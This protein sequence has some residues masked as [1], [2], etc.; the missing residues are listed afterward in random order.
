MTGTPL[1][2]A[3]AVNSPVAA[4]TVASDVR[5][6]DQGEPEITGSEVYWVTEPW[7]TFEGPTI[8]GEG[9]TATKMASGSLTQPLLSVK[10]TL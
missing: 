6:N 2:A 1:V 8:V 5:V 4:S 9:C 7:E 3:F 10:N